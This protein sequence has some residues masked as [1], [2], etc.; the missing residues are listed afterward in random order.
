LFPDITCDDIFRLET[1][2]LWLRW[3]RATDAPALGALAGL[4]Q[5]AEMTATLPHP[6][7]P[8]EAERFILRSR[9]ETAAGD[10]LILAVAAKTKS[11]PLVGVVSAVAGERHEVEI[12]Y[13]IAPAVAG[14][15]FASEAAAALVDA[16]FNLTEAR[17]VIANSR[18]VNPASR[19]VLEKCGF[20]SRG[21]RRTRCRRA[22][23]ICHAISSNST[24]IAGPGADAPAGSR[25]W[26]SNALPPYRREWASTRNRRRVARPTAC[27]PAR[28]RA[29]DAR[30]RRSSR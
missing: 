26:R 1:A 17:V 11:Q 25:R 15:G 19:R 6:Y 2:H 8:G 12:G 9:A 13:M 30:P 21:R 23:A 18:I 29:A 4:A 28:G 3:L 14:R 10:S 5:V 16:V 27:S 24:A 20:S 22:A 7:P